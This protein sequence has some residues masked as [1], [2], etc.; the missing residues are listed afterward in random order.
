MKRKQIINNKTFPSNKIK[1]KKINLLQVL[2]I[3]IF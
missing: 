2:I 1:T 3:S